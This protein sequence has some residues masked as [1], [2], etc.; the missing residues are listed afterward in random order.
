MKVT[1]E[2]DTASEDYDY[3]EHEMYKQ[4]LNMAMALNKIFETWRS[5]VKYDAYPMINEYTEYWD[6]LDEE[7]KNFYL[8]HKIPDLDKMRGEMYEILQDT[9]VN[10][11][12]M[13]Y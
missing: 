1:Y 10:L 4:A 11:E 2:F 6:D 3:Q 13:G 5:W 9:G 7:K 8:D 12:K